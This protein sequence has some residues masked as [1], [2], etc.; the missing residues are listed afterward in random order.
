[1][2]DD[3]NKRQAARD[4]NGEPSSAYFFENTASAND[5][6]G[7]TP[8]PPLTD[9][10]AESYLDMLGVP[11]TSMDGGSKSKKRFP[12]KERKSKFDVS[13]ARDIK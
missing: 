3:K 4:G 2:Q 6:T 5:F 8:T 10:D 11:V 13:G 9:E 7:M 1:M 12:Q